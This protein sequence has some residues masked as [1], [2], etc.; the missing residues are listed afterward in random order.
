MSLASAFFLVSG[1]FIALGVRQAGFWRNSAALFEHTMQVTE[2]TVRLCQ[3]LGDAYLEQGRLPKAEAMY[4]LEMRLTPQN[5]QVA[6]QIAII[7]LRENR[8]RDAEALLRPWQARPEAPA[9]LLNDYAYALARLD[10]G[11]EAVVA[12]QRALK[13]NPDYAYAHFGYANLLQDRGDLAAAAEQ[14]ADALT[15]NE[16]WPQALDKLAWISAHSDDPAQRHIALLMARHAVDLTGCRDAGSLEALA[17]ADAATGNWDQ[18]VALADG[19]LKLASA[20]GATEPALAL[21]RE[22]LQLYRSRRL[23]VR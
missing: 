22:R 11:D 19:A 14:Y 21:C 17:A 1:A 10:R 12:Y 9:G 16:D 18:A 23:P 2:P 6:G 20:D 13:A 15:I 8:W 3:L 5:M 7:Y 4:R